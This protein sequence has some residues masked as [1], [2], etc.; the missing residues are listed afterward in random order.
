MNSRPPSARLLAPVQRPDVFDLLH[1]VSSVAM[2][3]AAKVRGC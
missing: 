1:A 2:A 3:S